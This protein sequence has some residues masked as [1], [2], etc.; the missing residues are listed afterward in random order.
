[1]SSPSGGIGGALIRAVEDL[2][3]RVMALIWAVCFLLAV[4]AFIQGCLRLMRHANAGG[5][6]PSLWSAGVSFLIAGV[7]MALPG[8]LAGAGETFFGK[9]SAT[10]AMLA[11]GGG[12][13]D[14][15]RLV[16]ALAWIVRVVGLLSF[17]KGLFVLRGASDGAPGATVSGASMHMIGGVMAWHILPLLGAVQT[18]L[19]ISVLKIQ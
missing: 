1:M 6:G 18:T 19:G 4:F 17:V 16:A 13:A 8:V 15:G 11:Y 9:D 2:D 7:L 12:G 5:A 3:A 10:T 14:Y